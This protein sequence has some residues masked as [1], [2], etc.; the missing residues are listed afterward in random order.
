MAAM[1]SRGQSEASLTLNVISVYLK[2]NFKGS[3]KS[4]KI[5]QLIQNQSDRAGRS[6]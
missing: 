4:E 3:G 5:A 1:E 2:M 6:G